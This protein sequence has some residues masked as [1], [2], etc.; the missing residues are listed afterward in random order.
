MALSSH[1]TAYVCSPTAHAM[2]KS[3]LHAA[4][5]MYL[6]SIQFPGTLTWL[7]AVMIASQ[8]VDCEAKGVH[9]EKGAVERHLL[10]TCPVSSHPIL[11]VCRF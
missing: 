5:S 3:L 9:G 7:H 2:Q 1:S 4:L 8:R 11:G 10:L 6:G